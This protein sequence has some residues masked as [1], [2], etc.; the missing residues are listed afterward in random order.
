MMSYFLTVF[1]V[2]ISQMIFNYLRTIE[3]KFMIKDMIR[4]TMLVAFFISVTL[5]FSTYISIKALFE[6][7]YF[8]AGVYIL[9]GLLGKYLGLKEYKMEL[10]TR[11][12]KFNDKKRKMR[13]R[14]Q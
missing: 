11:F 6:G 5:L 3:I 8:I 7:D 13:K 1:L 9:G 2:I 14:K 10:M 12:F 4:E